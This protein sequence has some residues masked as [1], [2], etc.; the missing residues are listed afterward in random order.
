MAICIIVCL[1]TTSFVAH[2]ADLHFQLDYASV[3]REKSFISNWSLEKRNQK[4]LEA[5]AGGQ[6]RRLELLI[7]SHADL[8]HQDERGRTALHNAVEAQ[9]Q[10]C[11]EMLLEYGADV[12]SRDHEGWTALCIASAK[13]DAQW[14][15]C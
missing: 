1:W 14:P 7:R 5:A 2:I 11:V 12:N 10:D 9:F 13:N 15:C 3:Q 4:L 8:D 6:I